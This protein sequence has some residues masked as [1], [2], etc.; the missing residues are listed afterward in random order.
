MWVSRMKHQGAILSSEGFTKDV[1][2]GKIF[3]IHEENV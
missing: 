2:V 1:Q 3:F